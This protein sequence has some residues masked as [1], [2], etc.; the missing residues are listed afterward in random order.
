MDRA[1]RDGIAYIQRESDR[2]GKILKKHADGISQLTGEKLD[3][4]Q[5]KANV[6]TAFMND[7]IYKAAEQARTSLAAESPE[8]SATAGAHDEL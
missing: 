1:Q 6:L 3:E 5:R 2:V 4:L 7:R 8:A